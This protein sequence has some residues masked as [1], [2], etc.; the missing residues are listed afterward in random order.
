MFA[1][2]IDIT[3]LAMIVAQVSQVVADTDKA[4]NTISGSRKRKIT[5]LINSMKLTA[6]QKYMLM[7]Y[8]GYKNKNG[9]KQVKTYIQSLK[10]TKTEKE[11]LFKMCGY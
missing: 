2:A 3:K 10:L 11:T 8:F 6:V 1:Q 5:S 4:G 7:G 9:E